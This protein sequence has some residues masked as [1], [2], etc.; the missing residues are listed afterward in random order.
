MHSDILGRVVVDREYVQYTA[1]TGREFFLDIH[2]KNM[3]NLRLKLTDSRNRPLVRSG[4][5]TQQATLG[6]LEFSA[7]I[8][9]DVIKKKQVNELETVRHEPSVP[10][11]FSNGVTNQQR[12]GKDTFGK[13]PGF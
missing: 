9:I 8:R 13:A 10:A 6:N 7:V 1:Q 4:S 3:S 2:Q 5:G 11:R 12:Y